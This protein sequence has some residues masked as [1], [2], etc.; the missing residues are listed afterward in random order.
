[1]QRELQNETPPSDSETRERIKN[2]IEL[3]GYPVVRTLSFSVEQGVVDIRGRFPSFYLCQVAIEYVKR[4]PGVVQVINHIE[5]VYDPA[6]LRP[7]DRS[8]CKSNARIQPIV[9]RANYSRAPAA[10]SYEE[11]ACYAGAAI[12]D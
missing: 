5:V 9:K 2:A 7:S 8:D 11:V 1:M 12:H 6:S 3:S 4:V 10:P